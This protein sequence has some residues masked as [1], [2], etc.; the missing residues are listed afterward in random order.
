MPG[1]SAAHDG[2][3]SQWPISSTA[4]V[5]YMKDHAGNYHKAYGTTVP[6]DGES[7]WAAGAIFRKTDGG[8]GTMLYANVGS[9]TSC[10]FDAIA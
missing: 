2:F 7:R 4:P 3:H 9:A 6:T 5:K 10:D 8:V 1:S